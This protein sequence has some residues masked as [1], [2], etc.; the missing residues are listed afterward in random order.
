METLESKS[1]RYYSLYRFVDSG[2][3]KDKLDY[4]KEKK[5][6]EKTRACSMK[7][8]L[9]ERD[10]CGPV[11]KQRERKIHVTDIAF[12]IAI[13]A[14]LEF[15]WSEEPLKFLWGCFALI[16]FVGHC[17]WSNVVDW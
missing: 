3:N 14:T 7:I 4:T 15:M 17:P 8:Q 11:K 13:A 2:G 9:M 12:R 5:D 1:T 6:N 10:N 16:L